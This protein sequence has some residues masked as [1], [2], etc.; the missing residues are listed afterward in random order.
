MST[1]SPSSTPAPD[2]RAPGT[3]EPV[4]LAETADILRQ[5]AGYDGGIDARRGVVTASLAALVASIGRSY[6][7]MPTEVATSA[8]AV[9]AAVDRATGH[10]RT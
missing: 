1:P 5:V 9:V 3:V 6:Q 4:A 8:M 10:R 2:Q 7:D